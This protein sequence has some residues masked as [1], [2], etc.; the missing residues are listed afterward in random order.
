MPR[1]ALGKRLPYVLRMTFVLVFSQTISREKWGEL[2]RR[3]R[4]LAKHLKIRYNL[5][6]VLSTQSKNTSPHFPGTNQRGR[7]D[8]G[9][10]GTVL[11]REFELFS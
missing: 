5:S 6:L 3:N 2:S 4:L 11:P 9:G 10:G 7:L 1:S 8:K